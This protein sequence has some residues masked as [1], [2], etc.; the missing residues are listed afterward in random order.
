M[1]K[2]ENA[3]DHEGNIF[4]VEWVETGPVTKLGTVS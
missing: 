4:V 1:Y 3:R 2:R